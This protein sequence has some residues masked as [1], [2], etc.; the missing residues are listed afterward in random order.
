MKRLYQKVDNLTVTRGEQNST[1]IAGVV[2]ASTCD[3]VSKKQ[4]GSS[5]KYAR[6]A[7]LEVPPEP[8]AE[9]GNLT[10]PDGSK[11]KDR[12]LRPNLKACTSDGFKGNLKGSLAVIWLTME[13]QKPMKPN[14]QE[15]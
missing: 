8:L 12:G 10:N 15:L 4:S 14:L 9:E 2:V 5:I 11:I 3:F 1:D 13:C 7:N 6:E